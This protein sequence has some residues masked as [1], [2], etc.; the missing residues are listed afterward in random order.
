MTALEIYKKITE[1]K[2]T[3]PIIDNDKHTVA[4]ELKLTI[5][6]GVALIE[7][8][9]RNLLK[10]DLVEINNALKMS[11]TFLMDNKL[12][13][14]PYKFN[15]LMQVR[16]AKMAIDNYKIEYNEEDDLLPNV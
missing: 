9:A 15:T 1:S 13:T 5:D 12:S 6:E 11:E 3:P 16:K 7:Q 10:E 4:I 14:T 2:G 8:Y